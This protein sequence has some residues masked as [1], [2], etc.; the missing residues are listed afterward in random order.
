MDAR[1]TKLIQL[2]LKRSGNKKYLITKDNGTPFGECRKDTPS[3]AG[4]LGKLVTDAFNMYLKEPGDPN[5]TINTLRQAWV[6]SL[7]DV[8]IKDR[9]ALATRMG[10]SVQTA[11]DVYQRPDQGVV[12]DFK[13][14]GK[15]LKDYGESG[16]YYTDAQILSNTAGKLSTMSGFYG[17]PDKKVKVKSTAKPK[18]KTKVK[19]KAKP[20]AKAKTKAK[21][22]AATRASNRV[23]K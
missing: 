9:V 7:K 14:E 4:G 6:N 2:W 22:K 21:T 23:K 19:A 8:D 3:Q 16:Y 18:A 10:H 1:L 17:V 11:M 15:Q 13:E 12:S 5:I 20:K